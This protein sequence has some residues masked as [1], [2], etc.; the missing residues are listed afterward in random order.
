V[1]EAAVAAPGGPGPGPL[2]DFVGSGWAF[3]LR[4]DATGTF[5]LVARD[6]EIAEA[7]RLVLSTAPGERPMRPE[8]GC[9]IGEFAFAPAD[10]GTAGHLAAETR[11]ALERWEPRIV[12]D[13]V[14]VS[15]DGGEEGRVLLDV[16]YRIRDSNDER[17]LVYPFYTIPE[18]PTAPRPQAPQGE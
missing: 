14:L 11:R 6:Q 8:F 17:N 13:D 16:R 1:D 5:A 12:V 15:F 9:R 10:A 18:P 7:I 2:A 3:P 4:F